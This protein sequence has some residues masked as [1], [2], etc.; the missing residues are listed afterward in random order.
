MEK[1]DPTSPLA[2]PPLG[3]ALVPVIALIALLGVNVLVFQGDP[4]IP[5]LL[6]SVIA[7]VT[8]LALGS[9]WRELEERMIESVT[10]AIK[11]ILI[12]LVVGVLIGLWIISG[13]VPLLIYYGLMFISPAVFLPTACLLCAVVSLAIGSS[14]STAGTVGVALMAI[15][16]GMGMPLPLV[17]GAV[18]SGAYFG[19]KM[20]PLSET[21]NLSPAVAGCELFEHIRHMVYSTLPPF[22][23]ALVLYAVIGFTLDTSG[24]RLADIET[25]LAILRTEFNLSPLLLL[26]PGVTFGLVLLKVDALPSLIVGCLVG[27]LLGAVFQGVPLA[28]LLSTAQNGLALETSSP[29]LNELLNRGGLDSMYWTVGLI[30]LAMVFGGI[31]EAGGLLQSISAAILRVARGQKGVLFSALCSCVG[32]NLLA[33]DQYLSIVVPGRM[34]R[35]AVAESGLHLKNLSRVLEDGG[36]VSSPLIFWN[37]CGAYMG[38]VL[39]VSA[40]A[41]APYTFF[42]L[43]VP[44]MS[45][46]IIFSGWTLVPSQEAVAQEAEAAEEMEAESA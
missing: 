39:G 33:S 23:I 32:I 7:A 10:V 4:H 22:L 20:S 21:T 27:A 12:L 26:A 41:Y 18:V 3:V 6:A 11:P 28:T 43:L 19:D 36:T 9:S 31:M 2:H 37:T 38:S 1:L 14:W 44:V 29:E 34:F 16:G 17:A 15:G 25:L 35:P 46:L 13:V 42:N 30:I 8:C 40:L 5:L 24:S 45:T